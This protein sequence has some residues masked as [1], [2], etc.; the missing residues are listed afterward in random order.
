[1]LVELVL[2]VLVVLVAELR[3]AAAELA[4][5]IA[6]GASGYEGFLDAE[7]AG[8]CALSNR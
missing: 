1:M 2:L 8:V 6:I 4:V 5:G 7:L 3:T